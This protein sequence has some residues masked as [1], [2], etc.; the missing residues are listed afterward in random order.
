MIVTTSRRPTPKQRKVAK[1]FAN[2][3]NFLYIR[4]ARKTL[5]EI[6]DIAKY[7]NY[8]VAIV[9]KHRKKIIIKFMHVSKEWEWMHYCFVVDGFKFIKKSLLTKVEGKLKKYISVAE[10]KDYE[11]NATLKKDGIYIDNIKILG[12]MFVEC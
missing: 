9:Q 11:H 5:Y 12:G 4:R 7:H 3:F 6:I 8:D 2:I 10:R 1:T